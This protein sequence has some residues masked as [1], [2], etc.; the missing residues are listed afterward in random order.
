[1]PKSAVIVEAQYETASVPP[2]VEEPEIIIGAGFTYQINKNRDMEVTCSGKLEDLVEVYVDGV[3]LHKDHYTLRSGSTIITL[4]ASY[5]N[6]LT[7]G[8]HTLKLQYKGDVSA[9]TYFLIASKNAEKE[10]GNDIEE[11]EKEEGTKTP[12]TGDRTMVGLW[13]MS[14]LCTGGYIVYRYKKKHD[15]IEES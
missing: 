11:V 7:V 15:N 12:S 3:I 5:L 2:V 9:E 8:K 4:K 10:P 1:M 13:M 14:M 6:T